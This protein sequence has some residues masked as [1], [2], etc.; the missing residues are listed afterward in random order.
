M[1]ISSQFLAELSARVAER[2]RELAA[3]AAENPRKFQALL[4]SHARL[5]KIITQATTLADLEKTIR[6]DQ[7]LIAAADIDAELKSLALAEL[8]A[9]EQALPE[10]ERLLRVELQPP[11]PN[12]ERNVIIEIR[13]GTGG[14]EAALFAA[15]LARMYMRY[16]EKKGWQVE[17]MDGS[18]PE[19][20]GYKEIVFAIQGQNV[21]RA[22]QFEGG[23]HRVQRIPV[24]EA[25]GRIH[26]S[27]ATVAVLPEAEELD[28]IEIKPE[29]LRVDV[30]RAS[31]AGGQH[32]NKTDSAVRLT[33]LPTGLVV[34]SQAERSQHKNRAKALRVLRTHLLARQRQEAE[35]RLGEARRSQIGSGERSERI[36]TYNFPQNRLTDHRIHFTLYALDKVIEGELEA[37]LLALYEHY[38]TAQTALSLDQL[39][40]I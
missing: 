40:K 11:N 5:K 39:L 38:H 2:E 25:A 31:G 13:A 36:R 7:E 22:L 3:A 35:E 23:T 28:K 4:K 30:Y 6:N 18:S 33:H 10:A 19:L 15:D 34:A 20:G 26:T 9:A 32:V 1:D 14:N 16:A 12:D 17:I 21:F 29:D 8:A 27:T 37:L 24:T